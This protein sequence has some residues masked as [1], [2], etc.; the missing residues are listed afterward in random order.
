M[1]FR[2]PLFVNLNIYYGF[3]GIVTISY[4]KEINLL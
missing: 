1:N 4:I 3:Y 2:E